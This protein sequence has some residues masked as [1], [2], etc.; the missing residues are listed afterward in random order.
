MN[1]RTR[2]IKNKLAFECKC[3]VCSGIV[4]GQEDITKELIKLLE[5]FDPTWSHLVKLATIEKIV[6]LSLRLY[7]GDIDDKIWP[8]VMLAKLGYVIRD[9]EI[10]GKAMGHLQKLADDTKLK[11]VMDRYVEISKFNFS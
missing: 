6:D 7:V 9:G 3:C 10:H 11:Y 5:A 2:A 8:L 4:P 1:E